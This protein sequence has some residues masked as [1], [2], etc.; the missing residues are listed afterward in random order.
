MSDPD[1]IVTVSTIRET[2]RAAERFV[3]RTLRSGVD[4]AVVFLDTAQPRV[5]AL[6]EEH[7][8]VTV[9]PARSD[10]WR[11]RRPGRRRA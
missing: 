4:H 6:L 1:R 9:V 11:G 7:P 3:R 5:R 10:Y 8:Q 2:P